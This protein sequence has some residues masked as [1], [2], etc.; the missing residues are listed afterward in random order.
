MPTCGLVTMSA[1]ANSTKTDRNRVRCL[2]V[3]L[4]PHPEGQ[5][6]SARFATTAA[7]LSYVPWGYAGVVRATLSKRSPFSI[8]SW[9]TGPTASE[10]W[11]VTCT[12]SYC[13]NWVTSQAL[14]DP[15]P[16]VPAVGSHPQATGAASSSSG[17]KV[18][19]ST[20]NEPLITSEWAVAFFKEGVQRVV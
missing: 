15:T 3:S 19:V 20:Y 7:E 6:A 9:G 12:V 17:A 5:L 1:R 4:L 13:Q 14:R 2:P 16:V 11:A 18:L 10:C 8:L